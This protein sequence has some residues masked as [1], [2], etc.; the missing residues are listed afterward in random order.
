MPLILRKEKMETT[1]LFNIAEQEGITV[2][3]LSLCENI[4]LSVELDGKGFIALDKRLVG[5]TAAERVALAHELGHLATGATHTVGATARQVQKSEQAAHR[6]A[7]ETLVPFGELI[8]AIKS[9]E[10]NPTEL[11]ERFTVTEEFMVKA[12]HFYRETKSA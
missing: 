11:A 3:F 12:L 9:G 4:A 1:K 6:W 5:R 7:I 8:A 10:E 2:D